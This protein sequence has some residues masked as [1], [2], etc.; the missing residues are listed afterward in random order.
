MHERTRAFVDFMVRCDVLTFGDFVAKSG[1][2]TPY[3]VNAGR[4]RTGAQVAELGRFYAE[5]I[6]DAFGDGVDVLFGPAYKGIPLAVTTAIAMSERHGRDVGFC[7]DR[8]EAK[9]HGEGGQ[10][11]GHPLQDGDRVVVVE[12]VTTAGTSIR[13]TLPLLRAAADVEVVGLVVG[14]DRRERGTRGDV[15]ALDELEEEFGLRT[16][17]I[18]SIDDVVEHLRDHDVDGRR[19]ITDDDLDRIAAYRAEFGAA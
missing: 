1:R 10:L 14:V 11:V 6:D 3:F 15:S 8:K 7:F 17:S 2:K 13:S 12:D 9:D 5:V 19:V 4:Y 16:V 18:A